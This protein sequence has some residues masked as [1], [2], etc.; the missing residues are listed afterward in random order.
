LIWQAATRI[1]L[2]ALRLRNHPAGARRRPV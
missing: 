1:V 2:T